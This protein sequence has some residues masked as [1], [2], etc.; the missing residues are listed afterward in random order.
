MKS[1]SGYVCLRMMIL[2][3]GISLRYLFLGSQFIPEPKNIDDFIIHVILL[4]YFSE[5]IVCILLFLFIIIQSI[6]I[7]DRFDLFINLV[8]FL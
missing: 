1:F 5:P 8:P 2:F 6:C 3:F 4:K 7:H